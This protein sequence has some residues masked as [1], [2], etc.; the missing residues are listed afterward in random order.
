MNTRYSPSIKAFRPI[1]EVGLKI[2]DAFVFETDRS[3]N[4]NVC[5]VC[6]LNAIIS[7]IVYD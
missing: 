4:D 3:G 7:S 5:R 2:T 1:L 6:A